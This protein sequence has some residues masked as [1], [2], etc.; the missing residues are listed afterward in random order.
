[1]RFTD[2]F[3]N[4]RSHWYSGLL[5]VALLFFLMLA[6]LVLL[7]DATQNSARFSELYTF[8]LIAN[9]L[10][11]VVL[12]IMI[13]VRLIIFVREYRIQI[14]GSRLALRLVI[15]MTVVALIPVTAVYYF[16]LGFLQRGIDSWFDVRI[17]HAL[18]DALDLSRSS[19]D[20]RVRELV[21]DNQKVA[22]TLASVSDSTAP[23]ALNDRRAASDGAE[24]TLF[25][26]SGRVIA[27]SMRDRST[28]L[29]SRPDDAILFQVRQG[30]DY[31]GLD[32]IRDEGLFI[33]VISLVPAAGPL[34]EPRLLQ[35]LF[36]MP[37]R[38]NQQLDNVNN[39]FAFYKELVF[40]RGPLKNSFVVTL[41]LVLLLTLLTAV[42][43]AFYLAQRLVS[44]IRVL[45]AGTRSVAAGDYNQ[46][47]PLP[48]DDEFGSLVQSFN[49]MT[50]RI[51]L[52]QDDVR[53]SQQQT[54]RERAY[55]KAVL[56]G[57]T[58][59]VLT[60]D[61]HFRMRT[62]NSAAQQILSVNFE[63]MMGVPLSDVG[64]Q[65]PHAKEFVEHV[66]TQF[67]G[68]GGEWQ[69][70]IVV[71]GAEGRKA[72]MCRGAS[73]SGRRGS[74]KGFVLVFDDVTAL[75]QAQ[76]DAAWSEVA[77]RLAHEIKNPL[78]PIQLAA[79]RMR[80]RYA[81]ILSAEDYEL[82][83]RSTYTIV[84]QVKALE[85]MVKAFAEYAYTPSL[86]FS[87]FD[88]NRL[89]DE[90]ADLYR[91]NEYAIAIECQHPAER[92]L[93]HAD[94][95]RIRQLLH[96]LVKNA[97]E[98]VGERE[99]GRVHIASQVSVSRRGPHAE[100]R[101]EDNGPGI[102]EQVFSQVFE[103]Y[104]TT[105]PKGTGLGL[106]IVKKIAEEHGGTVWAENIPE[107]GAAVNVRLPLQEMP[108][109]EHG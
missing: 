36:P 71:Y 35:A 32:P 11:L 101:I 51:A 44:P 69:E 12:V 3:G 98:A 60:L 105:K 100:M 85:E 73:L 76:R 107:G 19:L 83:D 50:R 96:N 2:M 61:H 93:V 79:E 10:G 88:L 70:Q 4:F 43:L 65:F 103:P 54:E 34:Q 55:L 1:M 64:E 58:S 102:S 40:L 15:M 80:R 90:V 56:G 9:I 52:A 62:V 46:R 48:S 41:S 47:L 6:D 39:A 26:N 57:L 67:Q 63:N 18:Q 68:D 97:L 77:R 86:S 94:A 81:D 72:L 27:T 21:R 16:S 92:I 78:T 99:G 89:I 7:S 104:V 17:E 23:M 37:Q 53:S 66:L 13:A 14:M 30:Y 87:E 8:L 42:W 91:N 82:L 29:P 49:E 84:Q 95:G 5:P 22:N 28:I 20:L 24:L 108:Q 31:V 38:I 33:R 74:G 45:A 109:M 106:A 59:G 25:S 75:I